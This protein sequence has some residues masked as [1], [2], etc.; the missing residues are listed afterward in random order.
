[1]ATPLVAR[2]HDGAGS[3]GAALGV[4]VI[5]VAV[6]IGILVFVRLRAVRAQAVAVFAEGLWMDGLDERIQIS[7]GS[8]E[9]VF[10]VSVVDVAPLS[11]RE[12]VLEWI[13]RTQEPALAQLGPQTTD[14]LDLRWQDGRTVA[15]PKPLERVMATIEF[16][17]ARSL[18]W[19]RRGRARPKRLR[20]PS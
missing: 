9:P 1:M 6:V 12:G 7:N 14:T 10:N 5:L 2:H 8:A 18:R 15:H 4:L 17:D 11:T 16:T 20:A 19:R 3:T 13:G